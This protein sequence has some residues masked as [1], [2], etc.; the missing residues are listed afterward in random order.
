MQDT[1]LEPSIVSFE[2]QHIPGGVVLSRAE[3]WPHRPEDW[4]MLHTLSEGMVALQDG[5]VVATAFCTPF[6]D[7]LVTFNMIIVADSHRGRGLGARLMEAL[8][9]LAGP[10]AI[11]LVATASGY[12]LYRKMGFVE[13][14]RN[15]QH[16]GVVSH[17]PSPSGIASATP[18][19]AAAIKALDAANTGLDRAA[20]WD[21]LLAVSCVKVIR[22]GTALRGVAACRDFGR[23]KVV[24]PVIAPSADDAKRLI[25]A[26][27]AEHPQT[28]VRLDVP[29]SS[30]LGEWLETCGL[31]NVG[32]GHA[33]LRGDA[34]IAASAGVYALASQA[35]G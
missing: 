18:A 19:D 34:P 21:A 32:G 9:A 5:D 14:G 26:H 15:L 6:G 3:G 11:Q 8:I 30:G 2:R 25:S 23:G 28:F 27:L 13:T 1:L 17:I 24:G 4:E 29:A 16:Q 33:M 31:A 35:L 12:P 20:M 10:R 7:R 22:A